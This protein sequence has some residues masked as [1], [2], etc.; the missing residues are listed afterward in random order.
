MHRYFL[1]LALQVAKASNSNII[2]VGALLVREEEV[3]GIGYNKDVL[4]GLC[5]NEYGT[6]PSVVHA[7]I[8]AMAGKLTSD[9][10]LY[11]THC[12]CVKCAVFI[13]TSGIQEVVFVEDFKNNE[14]MELLIKKQIKITKYG[15]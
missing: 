15:S 10:I 12:P 6:K 8:A 9:C 13:A 3:V 1:N 7:E 5:E 2:Q 14:G 11:V 4:G